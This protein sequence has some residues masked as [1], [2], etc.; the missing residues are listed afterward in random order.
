MK[1]FLI[2]GV[3]SLLREPAIK[4]ALWKIVNRPDSADII[5][6]ISS[7]NP[8][9]NLW[10][11][12]ADQTSEYIMNNMLTV[13]FYKARTDLFDAVLSKTDPKGLF[14]EFGCGWEAES[15]NYLARHIKGDIHGF[16]SFEGLPDDWFGKIKKGDLTSKGKLPSVSENVILYA[17]WFDKTLPEFIA[18]HKEQ[19]SFLHV[20]CDIYSS[21]KTIFDLLDKQIG[22]GTVIQFDEYFNYPGWLQHEYKAFQEFISRS[23]LSYEYL[24][25]TY[26]YSVAV[27]IK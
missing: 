21:T 19:V 24:G 6:K 1:S 3:E 11:K 27:I 16:D 14:M 4:V 9:V 15:I 8:W 17:G 12:S 22:P 2:R 7:T 25:Y 20:D 26:E 23:G 13:P 5:D 10:S 18:A